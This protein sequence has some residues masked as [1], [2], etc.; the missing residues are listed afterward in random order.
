MGTLT[1]LYALFVYLGRPKGDLTDGD[2]M[3]ARWSMYARRPLRR[4]ADLGAGMIRAGLQVLRAK[5]AR[6][7][8]KKSKLQSKAGNA[9]VQE[10][11]KLGPTYVKLGQIASCRSDLLAPE[12]IEELKR[13]QDAVPA[14]GPERAKRRLEEELGKKI[15]DVFESFDATAL[16][17]ASLGQVHRAKLLDGTEVAIKIQRGELRE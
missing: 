7:K 13:L 12:Y 16:A 2:A 6:S 9:I 17:A 11:L 4:Q 10:L 15:E 1:L 5:L 8:E 3:Q 14:F